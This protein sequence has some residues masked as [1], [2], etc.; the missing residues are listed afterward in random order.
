MTRKKTTCAIEEDDPT[1]L[2]LRGFELD[3][4]SA[5][6][7]ERKLKTNSSD[8]SARIQLLVY[9]WRHSYGSEAMARKQL[10]IVT[11]MIQNAAEHSILSDPCG[12]VDRR[13]N[14]RGYE[15]CKQLWLKLL[16][17]RNCDIEVIKNAATFLRDDLRLSERLHLRAIDL[18]PNDPDLY[19][20]LAFLLR[21]GARK[22][23]T[24]MKQ[25]LAAQQQ[26]VAKEKDSQCRR[27]LLDDLAEIAFDCGQWSIARKAAM[28]SVAEARRYRN[29]YTGNAIH[30]G[31]TILG[32][33]AL[34]D[35]DIKTA[36]VHLREAA[37]TPGS[38]QLNSFGPNMILAQELLA[39]GE[40][41]AVISYLKACKDFWKEKSRRIDTCIERIE[42]GE[43]FDLPRVI[44]L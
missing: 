19:R 5:S 21:L 14:P 3:T 40:R 32:R 33:L 7:L 4:H 11:W 6:S 42:R 44:D 1:L 31:H 24:R 29:W 17:R 9:Y 13:L 2:S 22:N 36:L 18:Q 16:R 27:Y 39:A 37:K 15:Q 38:P 41:K 25:A 8:M 12:F 30:D 34:A 28:K 43:I 20:N 26:A 23:S 10:A 35:G